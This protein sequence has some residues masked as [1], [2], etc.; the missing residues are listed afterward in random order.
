[1]RHMC[2]GRAVRRR[3]LG[4]SWERPGEGTRSV[5]YGGFP[6]RPAFYPKHQFSRVPQRHESPMAAG[7]FPAFRD[8]PCRQ[9]PFIAPGQAVT[10]DSPE[11]PA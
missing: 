3:T 11:A 10:A 4:L 6:S 7:C 8:E 9:L 1:M 5:T 2:P